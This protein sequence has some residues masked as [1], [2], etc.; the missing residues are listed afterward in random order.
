MQAASKRDDNIQVSHSLLSVIESQTRRPFSSPQK[1]LAIFVRMLRS[2][3]PQGF[4]WQTHRQLP[5][6][7]IRNPNTDETVPSGK[8]CCLVFLYTLFNTV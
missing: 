7:H 4:D 2:G 5:N 1:R 8:A 6:Q 3:I